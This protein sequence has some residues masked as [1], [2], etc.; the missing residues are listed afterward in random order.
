MVA[1]TST[2]SAALGLAGLAPAVFVLIWSTGFIVARY[3]MPHAGPF[4]F[5]AWRFALSIP[6]FALWILWSRA[7]W[8]R[9]RAQWL[10]LAAVG[11]LMHAAY[12]GGI[13]AAVKGGLSAG[14][15]A[16]IAGLQPLLTAAWVSLTAEREA[17]GAGPMVAP[18]LAPGVGRRQW[19][20]L[21]LGFVGLGLVVQRKLS[22]DEANVATLAMA[23][24]ALLAMTA[25]T[26]YQ[27]RFVE[28]GDVRVAN[29]VQLGAALVVMLP[30][31]W[32]EAEPII[33]NPQSIGA[34]AWS[35]IVLTIGGS[36]L[37]LWLI[38][39]GAAT[40][41]TSLLYLVPPS[42]ALLAWLLFDEALTP[43]IVAGMALAAGGVWL[44]MS[45]LPT[46]PSTSASRNPP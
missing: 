13:W 32:I 41:V 18:G 3:G 2:R 28:P 36:S 20:G 35:V 4:G 19:A 23:V 33:W 37:L 11:V 1:E 6:L 46:Q 26:L 15:T 14:T 21:A 12:L 34:M 17:R 30:L 43:T 24:F 5:L 42:A 29:L 10:H 38:Q 31:A 16:L 39:R 8:P 7:T 40:R 9:T 22:L 45:P 27:K 25:G 44:V